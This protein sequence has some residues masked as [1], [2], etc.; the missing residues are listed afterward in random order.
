MA[1]RPRRADVLVTGGGPVGLAVAALL[2]TGPAASYIRVR[3]LD[4]RARADWRPEAMDLRV[5]ALSR[6][7]QALLARIGVWD[8]I[9]ARRACAYRRMHVWEGEQSTGPAALTFDAAEIG[10]PD[11]GAI[12]EDS[13][14]RHALARALA[15]LP[16]VELSFS[17]EL[18]A[19]EPGPRGVAV[20]LADG[21][22]T[23]ADLVIAADGATS[24]IRSLL[25]MPVLE[26]AYGQHALVAHVATA[27]PH[28]E[29]AWQR[30]LP[31]GPLAF[32]PLVDGRSSIV[33][34]LPSARAA[35]LRD[36]AESEF[37]AALDDASGGVLGAVRVTTPRVAFEL[38]AVHAL[39]YCRA[40]I[41]LL[42]DAAHCVHPLAGQG[43]NLGMLDAGSLADEIAAA[44]L[45]G[46]AVGDE[47]VLRRYERSRKGENLEM[48]LAFDT[49][50]R[51][52]RLPGWAAPLRAFGLA[53]VD[54]GAPLKH[55]FM[56]RALGLGALP[57]SIPA[58][59][60]VTSMHPH[61]E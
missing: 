27:K 13:L 22:S 15:R 6:A 47:R 48:L 31:G 33:W 30:F 51:L 29:T 4:S 52:F 10:E 39:R 1:A 53:A 3:V 20:V 45:R 26:H 40:G 46:E 56:R 7:S 9:A 57:G 50:N 8:E 58:G 55:A 2:A 59:S 5:Y 16:N 24:R 25:R 38:R 12:V 41:A 21:E 60:M 54:R 28:A 37:E 44:C 32:L 61:I 23:E 34:S 35:T 42:G 36:A 17:T 43:M 49:L 11:L 19:L 14:L 18:A